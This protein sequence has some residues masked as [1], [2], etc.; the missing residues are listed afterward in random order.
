MSDFIMCVASGLVGL[1]IWNMVIQDYYIT[2]PKS[3]WECS[4][5]DTTNGE[6]VEYSLKKFPET[7]TYEGKK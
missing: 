4:A 7:V 3:K 6:C 5:R 2:L 1:L